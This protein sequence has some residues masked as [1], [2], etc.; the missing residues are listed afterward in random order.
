MTID[1]N[2]HGRGLVL[3]AIG[4]TVL[5]L[6][7]LLVRLATSNVWDI[8]FWRGALMGLA[9]GLL[10]LSGKR[11]ATLRG[12]LVV[13]L[14]SAALLALTSIF[15]VLGVMYTQVANVV[16]ILSAAPL[17][18]AIFTRCFLKESVALHTWLAIILAMLGI[19]WIFSG[20]LAT[21]GTIGNLY[22][23]ASAACVGGNLTLLRR[24]PRLDRI[25]LIALG[26][27]LSA[28]IALPMASPLTL[29]AKSYSVLAVMGLLQMP[30]ATLLISNAT[31]Y[32]PSTE[33]A[34]FYLLEAVLGTLWGW[35]LLKESPP[36]ATLL[37]GGVIILT[38]VV[39]AWLGLA[40]AARV[41]GSARVVVG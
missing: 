18:A 23:L 17:F 20:S 24:C 16:V 30:L 27:G 9:L 33:V 28:L 19:V 40:R 13:S 14:L 3:A 26:G 5:S 37:G 15:F 4:V 21:G 25:P 12:K 6:D 34:L 32:L 35:W 22:A 41:D 39:H 2:N 36:S 11:L 7:S 38:L 10:C 8:I 29:D 1:L 31:R